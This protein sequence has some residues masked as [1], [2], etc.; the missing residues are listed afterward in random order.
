MIISDFIKNNK[1]FYYNSAS[2]FFFILIFFS[3]T[4]LKINSQIIKEN[5][6]PVN[7][8]NSN[9]IFINTVGLENFKDNDIYVWVLEENDPPIAMEGIDN[10]IYKTKTYFLLN[11]YLKRYSILQIIFYDSQNNVIK[12]YN[13]S[14]NTDN[15]DYKYSSPILEGSNVSFVLLK[16]V[17]IN[18]SLKK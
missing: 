16:C 14:R 17:E 8:N 7:T 18:S 12:S 6:V 9:K 3:I 10:K 5:W 4:A 1:R 13:Y 2:N 11:K 15:P